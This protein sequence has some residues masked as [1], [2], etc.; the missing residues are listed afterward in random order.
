VWLYSIWSKARTLA[1]AVTPKCSW[2]FCVG[3]VHLEMVKVTVVLHMQTQFWSCK[4]NFIADFRPFVVW[5]MASKCFYFSTLWYWCRISANS[6]PNGIYGTAEWLGSEGKMSV[7]NTFRILQSVSHK[8]ISRYFNELKFIGLFGS[9]YLCEQF[10]SEMKYCKSKYRNARGH[11]TRR[12]AASNMEQNSI[13]VA[14]EGMPPPNFWK[15]V[16]LC[17]E[18][19]FSKQNSVIRLK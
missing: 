5:K 4:V 13:G 15:T 7:K 18:R 16:I 6:C 3:K 17:F 8:K 9:T 11:D 10:L 19:R 2:S 1:K 12:I 14:R